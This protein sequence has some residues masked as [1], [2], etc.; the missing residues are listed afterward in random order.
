M[1]GLES[2]FL[3]LEEMCNFFLCSTFHESW[4]FYGGTRSCEHTLPIH[5][6]TSLTTFNQAFCVTSWHHDAASQFCGKHPHQPWW[7]M[8][9]RHGYTGRALPSC[10]MRPETVTAWLFHLSLRAVCS[11][12]LWGSLDDN[13]EEEAW[14]NSATQALGVLQ[15]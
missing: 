13:E 1:K 5:V 9:W 14:R 10:W 15:K 3:W 11:V 7:G 6:T 2:C 4:G 12:T 8:A